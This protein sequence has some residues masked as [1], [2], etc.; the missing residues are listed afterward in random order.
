MFP[1]FL[2]LLLISSPLLAQKNEDILKLSFNAQFQVNF[3]GIEKTQIY[4]SNRV[5]GFVSKVIYQKP[6]FI[7]VEYLDPPQIKGRIIIDDG[8]KRIEYLPGIKK[9]IR[10]LPSL[11]HP[12][13]KE[14]KERALKIML[15]NFNI[16]EIFE[17]K[18]L[19]RQ[20]YVI[21][22]YPKDSI[23]LFLKLWIDKKTHL[24]LRREKYNSEGKLISSS[25]YI[26]INF[27]K[28]FSKEKFYDQLP[29]I[30][31]IIEKSPSSSCYTLQEIKA[32]ANFPIY[33]PG[34]LP[35]GYI[36]QEGEVIVKKKAVKLSYTNGLEVIAFFQRPSINITMGPHK[37]MR[38]DNVRIRFKEGPYGK[39]L[40]W[41]R[42]RKTFVLMG[43]VP[44]EE[45]I[46][47]ARSIKQ[48]S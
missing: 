44:L 1:L 41:N 5:Y 19:E 37:Q 47:I 23:S 10:A 40:V 34:Y 29:R 48:N 36:F 8:E 13:V 22:L 4:T 28:H 45:L 35:P 25:H 20:V 21:S 12:Q 2:G 33:L 11:N 6:N 46:K 38:F 17:G 15:T 32:R 7:Y 42:K 18:I 39:T 16:S 14:K 43:E 3:E 31:S 24:I 30:P 9:K 26:K 27:N